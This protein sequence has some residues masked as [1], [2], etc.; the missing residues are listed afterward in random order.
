MAQSE[1]VRFRQMLLEVQE[2][3]RDDDLQDLMFLCSDLLTSRELS[4]VSTA[5]DLFTHLETKQWLST[6]DLSLLLELLAIIKQHSL[7]RKLGLDECTDGA[8]YRLISP[9]RRML[10][11]VSQSI[12]D[13]DLKKIKF[14]LIRT[15]S[16][17]KLKQDMTLLHLFSEL[18][19]KDLLGED[20][21]D[22]LQEIIKNVYPALE[23]RIIQYKT[24]R[25]NDI[26]QETENNASM[27]N[28]PVQPFLTPSP[29]SDDMQ[30]QMDR[31]S[32]NEA[33]GVSEDQSQRLDISSVTESENVSVTEHPEILQYEMKGDRRGMCVIF[34]NCNFSGSGFRV[35]E[36][37]DIDKESLKSVFQWLGFEVRTEQDCDRRRMLDVLKGLSGRDHTQADCVVCCVLSHGDVD[38][39]IATDGK[40][41]TFRELM[42]PLCPLQCPS[43]IHKPKLFFIQACRGNEEQRAAWPQNNRADEMLV[44]DARMPRDST[45]EA[46]DFLLAM[47]TVPH[48]VSFRE[49][50]KGTWFIQA[51]CDNMKLLVPSGVDLLTILTRVNH[52][53]SRKS[54][55]SGSRKQMP[56]PEFTLTKRVVFPIPKTHPPQ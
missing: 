15:L 2:S 28:I 19:K 30:D 55:S 6:D 4:T 52:D 22:H 35:R 27:S 7:I 40:R 56:Q 14:M 51:L 18:E 42:E 24:E 33:S 8:T 13:E 5:T 38:A 17:Q 26:A 9:Y 54:D 20:R 34:N 29:S 1:D 45:A 53:V 39:V 41:V 50:D 11:D 3:L 43:L 31:L 12:T 37:T 48:Y 21:V 47:S 49:K 16:R 44:S 25:E 46:A 23:K 32:L 36:G 10:F